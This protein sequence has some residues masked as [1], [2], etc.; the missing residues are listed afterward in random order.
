MEYNTEF[1]AANRRDYI[2]D[3]LPHGALGQES[4][5]EQ[6]TIAKA[7]PQQERGLRQEQEVHAHECR[8][9]TH[10]DNPEA[11]PMWE[12]QVELEYGMMRA[13]ADKLRDQVISATERRSMSQVGVVQNLMSDWLP[14]V[15][16]YLVQWV[17]QYEERRKGGAVPI[18]LPLIKAIDPYV[19]ALVGLREILDGI[20]QPDSTNTVQNISMNIG[21]TLEYELRVR[22]WEKGSERERGLYRN[23]RSAMAEA[24]VT[25]SHR[26]RRLIN[27]FNHHLNTGNFDSLVWTPWSTETLFRVGC[28]IMNAVVKSTGWFEY[29]EDPHHV[30][31]KGKANSPKLLVLPKADLLDWLTKAL[32]HAELNHPEHRPTVMPPKPWTSSRDGGYWTPYA[33]SPRLIRFKASNQCQQENAADEYDALDMPE[34]YA[35]LNFLQDTPYRVNTRVLEVF[36]KVWTELRW[37][38]DKACLPELA[39]R[40]LAPRPPRMQEHRE[41]N[42]GKRRT[43]RVEPD[44][45]TKQEISDW[46]RRASATYAFNAKRASRT[47]ACSTTLRLAMEFSKYEAIYFPHRLD[48]RGR[49]YPIPAYLQPQ[50]ND[51]ARGLL[52]YAKA[53]PITEENGGVRWLA[54]HLASC[55]G[56]DKLSFGDRIQWTYDNEEMLRRIAGDPYANKE[57]F[58]SDKPWQTL[59]AIFDW[60]GY[61]DASAAGEAYH[62]SL[63]VMVD[64]TCNGIQ[65]L[66]AL[67]RDEV[68][69]QHVNL[70]PS[71]RPSDIYKHVAECLQGQLEALVKDGGEFAG[72]AAWWLEVCGGELPRGLTKRQVMVLPYGGTHQSFTD[73]TR[74]WLDE[75]HRPEPDEDLGLRMRRVTFLATLMW[76]AVKENVRA[77]V[78]VMA[79]IKGYARIAAETGQPLF[80]T[81]PSGFT[82]RHFY[83]D[84][85][86]FQVDMR[87]DGFKHNL[88]LEERKA[89]LSV[90]DQLQ[91]IAPNFIHSLDASHLVS[92]INA[93]TRAGLVAVTAIHDAYGTHAA[94]MEALSGLIGDTFVA[95]HEHD[96]LKTFREACEEIALPSAAA[97]EMSPKEY[98]KLSKKLDKKKPEPLRLGALRLQEVRRSTYFFS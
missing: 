9:W 97:R 6:N 66:S 27:R 70:T 24:G 60:V 12:E 56:H 94:N 78:D 38:S 93:A 15:A 8:V 82:V 81:V 88:K 55:W 87:L 96:L 85:R 83:A 1:A 16:D 72:H 67:V 7:D 43:E 91:G 92:C 40:P 58:T 11:H 48:F 49:M 17:R 74:Q 76:A 35:A 5:S 98:Q 14:R 42:A 23:E 36:S 69:G 61:L 20:G 68:S 50:G 41:V 59:A 32:D 46:K 47:R 65:H 54:I 30:H 13:G 26:R 89:T 95:T 62:S 10:G 79:W 45:Q 84:T 33:R 75:N 86:S 63:P 77:A 44:A 18:V 2:T 73:Y 71:E 3:I 22:A 25:S 57:W 51:L 52:T 34:V 4:R 28:T 80:W 39:E 90:K 21:R 19:A 64:G 37:S 29:I 31:R 53:L